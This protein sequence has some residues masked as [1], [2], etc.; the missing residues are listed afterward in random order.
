MF[1]CKFI[2]YVS[3][4]K[5]SFGVY[6]KEYFIVRSN[7]WVANPIGPFFHIFF[8]VFHIAFHISYNPYIIV[9]ATLDICFLHS[10]GLWLVLINNGLFFN[11]LV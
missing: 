2:Y 8:F 6:H 1:V 5:Y 11:C 9:L 3:L 4:L 7:K 10:F